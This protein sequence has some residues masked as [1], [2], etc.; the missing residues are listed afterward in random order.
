MSLPR[1]ECP[2]CGHI[3]RCKSDFP[4][5][6]KCSNEIPTPAYEKADREV[7]ASRRDMY[8]HYGWPWKPVEEVWGSGR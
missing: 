5:C 1:I 6:S 8:L 2:N 7:A 3:Q 4:R